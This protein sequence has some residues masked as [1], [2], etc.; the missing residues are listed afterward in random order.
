MSKNLHGDNSRSWLFIGIFEIPNHLLFKTCLYGRY[1]FKSSL[2]YNLNHPICTWKEKFMPHL[3]TACLQNSIVKLCL[4]GLFI[5]NFLISSLRI[6]K[7]CFYWKDKNESTL[8]SKWN[9]I[10]P[11]FIE[12]VTL[13]IVTVGLVKN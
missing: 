9:H 13:Q 3:V 2:R 11:I 6:F 4:L 10:D 1:I 8:I 5:T 7:T 12:E